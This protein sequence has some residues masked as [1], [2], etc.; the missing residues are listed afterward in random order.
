MKALRIDYDFEFVAGSTAHLAAI[1]L[2]KS[3]KAIAKKKATMAKNK[4]GQG[5]KNSQYD[6]CWVFSLVEQ[7][8]MKIAKAELDSYVD[9]GW[10]AGR[11]IKF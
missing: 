2:S 4:H 3:P 9:Q 8:S 11:K 1:E 10:Q 5:A 7:K 6:T